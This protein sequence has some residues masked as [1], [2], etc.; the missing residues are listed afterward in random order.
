MQHML[1][2]AEFARCGACHRPWS[3]WTD[4]VVDP[5]VR[6]LGLQAAFALPDTN[7]LIFE[8]RCGS[9]VSILAKRLRHLFPPSP[10]A[11]GLP[12]LRG[13]AECPGHCLSL[14]DL[15]ACDRP[16]RN[17]RDRDLIRLV[18]EIQRNRPLGQP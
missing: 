1:T 6:L 5:G 18:Q 3:S 14:E 4:F 8:H 2:D 10:E 9:T 17:A 13:T 15:E 12:S 7:L 11:D 16:C